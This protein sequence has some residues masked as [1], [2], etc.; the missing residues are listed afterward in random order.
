MRYFSLSLAAVALAGLI[1]VRA[2]D[3]K[4]KPAGKAVIEAVGEGGS[5]PHKAMLVGDPALPT[6]TLYRPKDLTPFGDELKLPIVL[7]GNG[8][9]IANSRGYRQFLAEI[10]SHGFLVVAIG[11][12]EAAGGKGGTSK[13]ADL[14]VGLDW[15][16]AQNEKGDYRGKIDTKT[17]A[18]MGHS[19]GLQALEVASDPRVTT[20]VLWNSGVLPDGKSLGPKVTRDDLNKLK[21]PLAYVIGGPKDI[22]TKN[23]EA[24]FEA[25]KELP[26]FLAS[27]EVGHGGTF[28]EKNGGTFGAVGVAWLKWQLKGDKEAAK[29]FLGATPGLAADTKWSVKA[30][31]LK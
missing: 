26:V 6:H 16:T 7:W 14:L 25:I 20:A 29:T 4:D 3:A 28:A 12:A 8:G 30:K 9:G 15:A 24:D 13:S 22:A 17:V 10:A 1:P 31:N 2:Q 27:R 5:G 18:A 11:P 23:A 19:L 21:V